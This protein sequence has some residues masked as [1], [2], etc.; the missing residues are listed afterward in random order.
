MNEELMNNELLEV[1]ETYG[2]EEEG[3]ES[4]GTV[5][6][7]VIGV[8]AAAT[9]TLV[10]LGAKKL[11]KKVC[12]ASVK[13]KLNERKIKDLEADGYVIYKPEDVEEVEEVYE[14]TEEEK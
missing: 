4:S 3:E 10:A 7:V 2:P 12:P 14:E 13:N 1:E 8:G 11:F 5:K 6:K 9:A